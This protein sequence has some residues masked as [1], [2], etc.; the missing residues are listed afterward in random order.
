MNS[1]KTITFQSTRFGEFTVNEETLIFFK[2]GLVGFPKEERFVLLDHKPPFSWLHSVDNPDLAFVVVEGSE[3][4]DGYLFPLPV[5]DSRCDL[6]PD[7]EFATLIVV[8]VRAA[9]GITTANLK[10]PLVINLRNREGVQVILDDSRFST[11]F[12][13]WQED[14]TPPPAQ[15]TEKKEGK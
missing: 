1:N 3:F 14:H 10:A 5:G 8:T 7:D 4:G 15:P 6:K 9:P 11:R 2:G 13:L 12:P